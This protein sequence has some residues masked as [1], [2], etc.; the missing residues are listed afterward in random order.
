MDAV[1]EARPKRVVITAPPPSSYYL[2]RYLGVTGRRAGERVE[3]HRVTQVAGGAIGFKASAPNFLS[4]TAR[5]WLFGVLAVAGVGALGLA[6]AIV[7]WALESDNA[8][9]WLWPSV[10]S[11][12]LSGM[13][14][15]L[16]YLTVM[17][18]GKVDVETVFGAA[19]PDAGGDEAEAP[20]V[21]A[22]EPENA[23]AE[24][25][26][27]TTVK[28][29]FSTEMDSESVKEA[30]TLAEG[31]AAVDADVEYTED[32]K[33]ATLAPKADLTPGS[34]YTATVSKAA[35]SAD[36]KEMAED[37]TWA[38]T[39]KAAGNGGDPDAEGELA[40]N[41]EPHVAGAEDAPAVVASQPATHGRE[42]RRD[43]EGR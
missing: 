8:A 35:K 19:A 41:V 27:N 4:K 24:V 12:V 30:F 42:P 3:P 21:T 39:V 38:F 7:F 1:E 16:A 17:G 9:V 36:G 18:F 22:Q 13:L 33:T 6:A 15:T 10:F 2:E 29:T 43:A 28:A 23:A 37:V 25:T 34:S 20:E 40:A 26:V 31:E 14:F 32:D 5:W 11:L